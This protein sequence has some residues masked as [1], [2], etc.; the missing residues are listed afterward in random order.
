MS[1]L[2]DNLKNH[3]EGPHSQQPHD[4]EHLIEAHLVRLN[5]HCMDVADSQ[6]LVQNFVNGLSGISRRLILKFSGFH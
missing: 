1:E 3:S 2:I 6:V 5:V 4:H